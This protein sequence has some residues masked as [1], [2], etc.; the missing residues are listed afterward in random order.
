MELGF[1]K[2]DNVITVVGV[3]PYHTIMGLGHTAD[4]FHADHYGHT[5]RIR[6][7]L[8]IYNGFAYHKGYRKDD[9]SKR[10]DER[11]NQGIY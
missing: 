3:E 7:A 2:N 11:E 6:Q 8:S 1:Q 5:D 9:G 10:V 4:G